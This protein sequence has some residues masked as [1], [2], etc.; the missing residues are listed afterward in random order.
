MYHV[1]GARLLGEG[2]VAEDRY[3][4]NCG[5]ALQPEDQFCGNCGRP[6]RATARVPTPEADVPV[7][8]PPQQAEAHSVPSPAP[9]RGT[10]SAG[11]VLLLVILAPVLLAIAWFVFQFSVGFIEG[12]LGGLG[13]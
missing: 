6:V 13:G 10:W 5:Q 12:L 2:I 11:R 3:C 9:Q 8:P 1:C 7:P 4:R